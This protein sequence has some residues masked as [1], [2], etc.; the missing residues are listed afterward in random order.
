MKKIIIASKNPV[1]ITAALSGFQK[2]FPTE[3]FEIESAAV[4]SGV[5]HQPKGDEEILKGA[6]NRVE[7]ADKQNP[8]ADFFVGIEGGVEE[9]EGEMLTFAWVVVKSKDGM[10]GRGRSSSFFLPPKVAELIRQGKELGE[11]DD[12]VFGRTNS[13]QANGA[14]GILTGDVVDRTKYYTEALVLALIPF[15]NQGLYPAP[16]SIPPRPGRKDKWSKKSSSGV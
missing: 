6:M 11:A 5:G 13:K 8:S 4:E 7:N 10:V 1:K 14:V 9:R 2:M 12:I 3:E 15:K 16:S